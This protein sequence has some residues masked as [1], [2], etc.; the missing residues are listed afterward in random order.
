MRAAPRLDPARHAVRV[1]GGQDSR[2]DGSLAGEEVVEMLARLDI[3]WALLG[4]SAVSMGPLGP[5]AMDFDMGK[6]AVKRVA[7]AAGIRTAL[8]V[9]RTKSDRRGRIEIAPLSAFARVCTEDEAAS[10]PVV[11]GAS[12]PEDRSPP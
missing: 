11:P 10:K 1:L 12:V 9:A 8:L 7:M 3:D 4:C 6:I 5:R 2:P